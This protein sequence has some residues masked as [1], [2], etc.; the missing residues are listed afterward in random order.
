[1]GAWFGSAVFAWLTY[2]YVPLTIMTPLMLL[3]GGAAFGVHI[4]KNGRNGR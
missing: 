1:M 4:T 3:I 2:Q